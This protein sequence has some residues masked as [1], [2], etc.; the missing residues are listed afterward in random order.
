MR[1]VWWVLLALAAA[2]VTVPGVASGV[3]S[4]ERSAERPA[5]Q[6]PFPCGS[7]WQLNT[8]GHDPAL[9]MVVDGNTGSDGLPVLASA[10]GTVSATYR[11]NGSGNTIQINHG[12]GWFTAY[13]HLKDAPDAYVKKGD[14]VAVGAAIGRIGT[15][16]ASNWAHLH[17]E[18]RYL[19]KGDFTDE[20]HRVP[21]LLDGV[22]YSGPNAS[23]TGVVSRNCAGAPPAWQD[24]PS[25]YVCFY[26]G[27]DGTG[28]VCRSDS[29]Q[30][31]SSCGFR[32]SYFNNGSPQPGY[33]HVQVSFQGGGGLCLHRG[34]TEGRGS[35]PDG[36]KVVEGFV[37]R[38][39]C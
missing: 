23:W 28:S 18:Q 35:L 11:D 1:R 38:G 10:A 17:Y 22:R 30:P 6:L 12:G 32:R 26:D 34:W 24:C 25:G 14:R 33:D 2:L 7:V 36:G 8:W 13:Y 20:R 16:G 37:W 4:A 5:F 9:D 21:S 27:P 39:E 3:A 19:A 15:S 31:V 29:D